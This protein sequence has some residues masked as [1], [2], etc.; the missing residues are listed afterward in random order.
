MR[1][2]NHCGNKKR[3]LCRS[4]SAKAIYKNRG[5]FTNNYS[6]FWTEDEINL[7]R[8]LYPKSKK[9][10]L[11]FKFNRNWSSITHKANRLGLK[12]NKIFMIKGNIKGR[13][14]MKHNNPMDKK[15]IRDK[16]NQSLKN[17]WI[18]GKIKLSGIALKSSLGLTKKENHPNWL[19]GISFEPYN[20]Y[21]DEEFRQSIR[22]RDKVCMICN[23][24]D[25][26]QS[27]SIHHINYNKKLSIKENCISLCNSCHMKTNYNR[28]HWI[29]FFQNL[30]KEKYGYDYL[31]KNILLKI[32]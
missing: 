22:Q 18:N 14:T 10:K 11:M 9:N 12:R 29:S 24:L 1:K 17:K 30:L 5:A 7:L 8:K 15:E 2:T 27:L 26:H 25:K 19:G 21:W 6:T 28:K 3:N 16:A 4:C 31:D 13:A 32:Q 20:Q 23:S